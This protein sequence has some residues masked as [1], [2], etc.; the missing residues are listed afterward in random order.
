MSATVLNTIVTIISI[1][2]TWLNG[3][4]LYKTSRHKAEVFKKLKGLEL[5]PY[6]SRF[7]NIYS[8]IS[9]KSRLETWN[10]A[11]RDSKLIG[12]LNDVLVDYSQVQAAV[13]EDNLYVLKAEIDSAY[14]LID[15][16]SEGHYTSKK[17]M[18]EHLRVIDGI[19]QKEV[20]MFKSK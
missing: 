9:N 18:L 1:I 16:F 7:H 5:L 4:F 2:L 17:N 13:S 12:E 19:L 11:G 15:M 3:C 10:Q 8:E 20:D 14:N 6:A